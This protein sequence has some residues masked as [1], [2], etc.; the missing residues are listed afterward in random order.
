MCLPWTLLTL[1]ITT[2]QDMLSW[3]TLLDQPNSNVLS[4]LS[5]HGPL[6]QDLPVL[7]VCHLG[8]SSIDRDLGCKSELQQCQ[9][10]GRKAVSQWPP[11]R[12][13]GGLSRMCY[14]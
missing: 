7:W 13:Q 12:A 6:L 5:L 10:S 3:P 14:G 1:L 8:I 11:S 9:E 4:D 2:H